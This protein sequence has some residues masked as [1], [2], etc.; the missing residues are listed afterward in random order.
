MPIEVLDNSN[1]ENSG[2]PSTV[3]PEIVSQ[4]QRY[5]LGAKLEHADFQFIARD[6]NATFAELPEGA[7][8][9]DIDENGLNKVFRKI[10][11]IRKYL[12]YEEETYA[13]ITNEIAKLNPVVVRGGQL[14]VATVEKP[15]FEGRMLIFLETG[16]V[17]GREVEAGGTAY[18]K[19]DVLVGDQ[20][21]WDNLEYNEPKSGIEV[22]PINLRDTLRLDGSAGTDAVTEAGIAAALI[23]VRTGLSLDI[24]EVD[25]RLGGRISNVE[26]RLTTAEGS[27][28]ENALEIQGLDERLGG[29]EHDIQ[30]IYAEQVV[31]HNRL[32]V[33]EGKPTWAE[34]YKFVGNGADSTFK[35]A[36]DNKYSGTANIIW[37]V[38]MA[39]GYQ[40]IQPQ[41]GDV[42]TENGTCYL[43]A[44]FAGVPSN[45]Q[46]KVVVQ[47]MTTTPVVPAPVEQPAA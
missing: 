21:L 26:G 13:Y 7:F 38:L 47:G 29:A 14:P 35:I 9:T 25:E 10:G 36:L 23:D 1:E 16:T 43:K 39:G 42:V 5:I 45:S 41:D 8:G 32:T 6:D 24:S 22:A 44:A 28:E 2:Q 18:V 40:R 30:E 33:L 4:H 12:A 15:L 34:E 20:V 11:G 3:L 46:F 31:T 27:I 17:D 37:H 19:E